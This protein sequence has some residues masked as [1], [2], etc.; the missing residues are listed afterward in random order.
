[1][2]KQRAQ[3]FYLRTTKEIN[4][5]LSQFDLTTETLKIRR[6]PQQKQA[7]DSLKGITVNLLDVEQLLPEIIEVEKDTANRLKE[8]AAW[9][10]D[11]IQK[12]CLKVQ[13]AKDK[14]ASDK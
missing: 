5:K 7:T 8:L 12:W 4:D 13:S 1:M 2:L 3:T 10:K 11:E 14:A 9:K 6:G